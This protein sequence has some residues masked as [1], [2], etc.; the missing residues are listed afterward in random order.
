MTK[1][2]KLLSNKVEI[3]SELSSSL[4]YLDIIMDLIDILA[5]WLYIA[6]MKIKNNNKNIS[7]KQDQF[8]RGQVLKFK[9]ITAP[10]SQNVYL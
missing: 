8:C 5:Y 6:I 2:S 1:K 3:I 4:L 7:S 9:I 10:P